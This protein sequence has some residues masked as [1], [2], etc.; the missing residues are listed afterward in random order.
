MDGP[1]NWHRADLGVTGHQL[2]ISDATVKTRAARV[3]IKLNL[4]DRGHAVIFACEAGLDSREK[5][6]PERR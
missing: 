4:A 3:L 5:W 1:V 6:R 2:L